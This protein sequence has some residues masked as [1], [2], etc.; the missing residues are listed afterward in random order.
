[1]WG[2]PH[3]GIICLC[4]HHMFACVNMSAHTSAWGRWE[5]GQGQ[6]KAVSEAIPPGAPPRDGLP[7]ASVVS[8]HLGL[9]L[10]TPGAAGTVG[11]AG[12]GRRRTGP[13][14]GLGLVQG[15]RPGPD[16]P[17][18]LASTPTPTRSPC[19]GQ[20]RAEPRNGSCDVRSQF[21]PEKPSPATHTPIKPWVLLIASLWGSGPTLLSHPP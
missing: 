7:V 1:M 9:H 13:R 17:C 19:P 6:A 11:W 14:P 18:Q 2:C 5:G 4:L 21:S 15:A 12:T 8:R 20:R 16:H 3:I 10:H